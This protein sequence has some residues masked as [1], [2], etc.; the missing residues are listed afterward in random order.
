MLQKC[1]KIGEVFNVTYIKSPKYLGF[2]LQDFETNSLY[3]VNSTK[4]K[5]PNF[6]RHVNY[7][8]H[9]AVAHAQ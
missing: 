2:S 8:L 5:I 7:M 1:W 4:V 3:G 6:S 9:Y